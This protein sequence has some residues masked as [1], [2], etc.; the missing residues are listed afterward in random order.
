[1]NLTH[2][3]GTN[4]GRVYTD[5]LKV[6]EPYVIQYRPIVEK[7]IKPKSSIKRKYSKFFQPATEK[8]SS[9]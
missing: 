8:Q 3:I 9:I 6:N 7:I 1:M 5:F 2:Y 4:S